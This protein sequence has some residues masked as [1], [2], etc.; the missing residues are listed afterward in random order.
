M[1]NINDIND[2]ISAAESGNMDA[3]FEI[4]LRY[5]VDGEN[6]KGF[7]WLSEAA[8]QGNDAALSMLGMLYHYGQGVEQDQNKSIEI[9]KKLA[10]QGDAD[11]QYELAR[12]YFIGDGL[13]RNDIEA[14]RWYSRAA[15]QGHIEAEYMV[16]LYYLE[17]EH[18]E[19]D[20]DKGIKLLAQAAEQ[21]LADAQHEL[22]NCYRYGNGVKKNE[23][24]AIKW[25]RKAA[26]QD[27]ADSQYELASCYHQGEGVRKNSKQSLKWLVLSAEQGFPLA[28]YQ[29]GLLYEDGMIV[30]KDLLEAVRLITLSAEQG[31]AAAQFHLSMMYFHGDGVNRDMHQVWKWLEAITSNS[32]NVG[33]KAYQDAKDVIEKTKEFYSVKS[34]LAMQPKTL[35]ITEGSTDWRHIEAAMSVLCNSD[36][37][38]DLFNNLEFEFLKYDSG[39]REALGRAKLEMGGVKLLKWC[40]VY[41]E[42]PQPRKMIFIVDNDDENIS[43]HLKGADKAAYKNWG[44]NVYSLILPIPEHRK[45]TPRICIEHLYTDAEIMTELEVDGIKRRLYMGYEFDSNG[46][47][48][49]C[50]CGIKNACG[51][52]KINIIDCEVRT[53][54]KNSKTNLALS[55]KRFAEGVLSRKPPFDD[56]S[57]DNFLPIFE[58]IRDILSL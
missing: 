25:Y 8:E 40:Q 58:T 18:I 54:E 11:A 56:F 53:K 27:F 34:T 23:M 47:G 45:D 29:L 38:K 48:E 17:G 19:K 35:I 1:D 30:E 31:E 6:A 52:G 44:N 51:D 24:Q 43:K 21:G 14:I 55:K 5:C 32:T 4:G 36:D 2:R 12:C 57:F 49:D 50:I 22:A 26:R 13:E 42:I 9:F 39:N 15:E 10:N 46:T 28:Q 37:Y 20:E 3:Q 7:Y 16:G 41:A 33:T